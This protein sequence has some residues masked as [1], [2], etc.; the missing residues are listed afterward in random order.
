D[1]KPVMPDAEIPDQL[2]VFLVAVIML[3]GAVAGGLVLDLAGRV[4]KGVP[5]RAAAAVLVDGALDLIRRGRGAPHKT[6]WKWGRGVRIG[7]RIL[8]RA[9][10]LRRCR[11]KAERREA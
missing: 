8:L 3:V 4:R 5:D 6:I 2:N 7:G 9:R 1:R 10:R 11:G